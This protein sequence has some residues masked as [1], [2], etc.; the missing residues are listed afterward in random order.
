MIIDLSIVVAV[1]NEDPS[2]LLLLLERLW[3]AISPLGLSYEVVFVNDGSGPL[4][5][6]ALV[7]IAEQVDNVKVIVLSRNFGQQAA[8]SAG[9][10]HSDG[11]A[12]INIDSDL[13]DPP[14]LIGE[15]VKHWRQGYDVVYVVRSTRRDRLSKRLSAH[16]FYRVLGTL[17]SVQIPW[18]TGDY[19]LI[20]RK[21]ANALALLPEKTRFLRGLIPWLGF[22]QVGIPVDRDARQ[23][24]VSSYTIKKLLCLALDG[25]ISFGA[26]PLY[27]VPLLGALLLGITI[28]SLS[29][30]LVWSGTFPRS[31]D[32]GVLLVAML[33]LTSLQI[34]SVGVVAVYLSK[35]LDEVRSRPTYI[36]AERLGTKFNEPSIEETPN[37][38]TQ[39]K[40]EPLT[41]LGQYVRR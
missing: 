22:R 35:V 13:Q 31:V 10:A 33:L 19:R 3:K 14:E 9:L 1:Y 6:R 7:Q 37:V 34:F 39:A 26:A 30:W 29:T 41:E 17:S 18:D 23:A 40:T 27:L 25:L 36:V 21:V 24:G 38:A 15:M 11:Q 8:I 32:N 2:N 20:D 28:L 5:S 4:T 12:I 16:L